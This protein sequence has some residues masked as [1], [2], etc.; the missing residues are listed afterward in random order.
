VVQR[1]RARLDRGP[2]RVRRAANPWAPHLFV[3]SFDGGTP[4]CY[5]GCTSGRGYF[6]SAGA[7]VYPGM[8]LGCCGTVVQFAVQRYGTN[9]WVN[10]G[11]WV[12]YFPQS[13]YP[14]YFNYGLTTLQAGGEVA[15]HTTSA[16]CSDMGNGNWGTAGNSAHWEPSSG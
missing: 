4:G 13:S 11:T 2:H 5:N 10:A 1:R 9:W 12:G 14:S 3:F 6:Q 7:S 8:Q 16:S 15:A